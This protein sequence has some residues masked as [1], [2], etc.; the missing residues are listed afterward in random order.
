MSLLEPVVPALTVLA[1]EQERGIVLP[2]SH[3][4]YLT[5]VAT[6]GP[7][8]GYGIFP[9][10]FAGDSAHDSKPWTIEQLGEPGHPF[11]HD[12]AWN[13]SRERL[14][15]PEGLSDDEQNH[16]FA[17]LDR[18][19]FDP[20]HV[21]GSIPVGHFGCAMWVRLVVNGNHSGEVWIDDRASDGGV[22]PLE[23]CQFNEWYLHWLGE[24]EDQ[25]GT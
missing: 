24:I 21:A 18:I 8:P 14:T 11:P 23:P 19:Y 9:L 16:W 4:K 17:D 2:V 13:L 5:E 22:Y 10:G 1:W 20:A 3:R 12:R 7:G 25:V 15:P 6:G